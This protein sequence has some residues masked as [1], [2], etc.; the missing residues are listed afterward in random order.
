MKT[1]QINKRAI[2]STGL[3]ISLFMLPVTAIAIHATHGSPAS[4]TWLHLHVFF[5]V[6]FMIFGAFHTVYNRQVLKRHLLGKRK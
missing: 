5:G 1:K 6:L 3:F 2:I 4:H